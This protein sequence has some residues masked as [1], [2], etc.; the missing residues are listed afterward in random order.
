VAFLEG[1]VDVEGVLARGVREA[2]HA[3]VVVVAGAKAP[4]AAEDVVEPEDRGCFALDF[5]GG[6]QDGEGEFEGLDAAADG[7]AGQLLFI[8]D[9]VEVEV[10]DVVSQFAWDCHEGCGSCRGRHFD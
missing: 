4:V 3:G 5:A 1:D 7:V 9:A 6:G 10:V 8:E 2:G